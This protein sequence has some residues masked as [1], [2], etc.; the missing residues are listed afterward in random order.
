MSAYQVKNQWGGSEAPW[1]SAGTWILGGRLDQPIVAVDI[2]SED[3]GKTLE[4]TI[5]YQTEGPIGFKAVQESGNSYTCQVQW[6]GSKAE[7]HD[8]GIY[9]IGDREIQRCIQLSATISEDQKSLQGVMIYC[10][11]GEIGFHGTLTPSY[12]VENQ[13]GGE[14]APWHAGGT[15][16]LTGRANQDVEE[17]DIESVDCGRTLEGVMRYKGEGNI[18][19]KGVHICDNNYDTFNQWG[20][21]TAPWHKAGQ[22]ILGNRENQKVIQLKLSPS[23]NGKYVGEMTYNGEGVIGFKA[24]Q[25]KNT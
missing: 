8:D 25:S 20:G 7:W 16:V 9:V 15:W 19:F 6:G 4:G 24:Q 2:R 12:E 18:G 1:H 14:K 11:E 13:W 23:K 21:V 5:R 3:Q 22:M 10:G 17:I